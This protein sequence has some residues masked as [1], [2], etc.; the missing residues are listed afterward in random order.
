VE[1]GVRGVS[2]EH[3]LSDE[4]TRRHNALLNATSIGDHKRV[5]KSFGRTMQRLVTLERYAFVI[6][7][8][9]DQIPDDS[10]GARLPRLYETNMGVT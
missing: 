7:Q 9:A 4:T 1:H 5:S 10:Y 6:D 3:G 2:S 8:M